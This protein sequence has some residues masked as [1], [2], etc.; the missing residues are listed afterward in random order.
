M[1]RSNIVDGAQ[2]ESVDLARVHSTE[3]VNIGTYSDHPVS[4]GSGAGVY[5]PA[6]KSHLNASRGRAWIVYPTPAYAYAGWIPSAARCPWL[7]LA[8]PHFSGQLTAHSS[9]FHAR[10][11]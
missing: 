8:I 3:V 7:I 2:L 1:G 10:C 6:G 9:C 5:Q 4:G 11:S